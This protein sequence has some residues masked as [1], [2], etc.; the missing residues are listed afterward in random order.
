MERPM[1]SVAG[2]RRRTRHQE[3][4]SMPEWVV[5]L[6][7]INHHGPFAMRSVYDSKMYLY[8]VVSLT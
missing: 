8:T 3:H 1:S 2:L 4:G 7:T 5:S 6:Y